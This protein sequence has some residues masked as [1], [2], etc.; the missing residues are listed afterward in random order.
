MIKFSTHK[1]SDELRAE[2][3]KRKWPLDTR[4][5]DT[6]GDDHVKF[7]FQIGTTKGHV[8]FNTVTGVFFGKA[9][10]VEF[11]SN[12]EKLDRKSWFKELLDVCYK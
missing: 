12:N 11:N 10:G 9:N 5:Y 6:R 2:C 8:L 1:T 7:L 3:E 4:L